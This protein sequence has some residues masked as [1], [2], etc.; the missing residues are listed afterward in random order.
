MCRA[1]VLSFGASGCNRS[2][3][4]TWSRWAPPTSVVG[5]QQ[6][7]DRP[8]SIT[9]NAKASLL[10]QSSLKKR[11][12]LTLPRFISL[13][14]LRMR[15]TQLNRKLSIRE[16]DYL[17]FNPHDSSAKGSLHAHC[18]VSF[19]HYAPVA[20]ATWGLDY[21]EI[22]T[23]AVFQNSCNLLTRG[24]TRIESIISWVI[25]SKRSIKLP[26]TFHE[27]TATSTKNIHEIST[28]R[29]NLC[30]SLIINRDKKLV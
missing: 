28:A 1:S 24:A 20:D 3:P 8:L 29:R 17:S 25:A 21:I 12:I 9:S 23:V 16:T 6:R 30:S 13:F 5:V 10:Q 27:G 4:K 15:S 2:S 22:W 18:W 11:L 7:S 26:L 14:P 19:T